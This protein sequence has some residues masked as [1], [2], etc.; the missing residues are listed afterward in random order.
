MSPLEVIGIDASPA[1]SGRTAI[2]VRAILDAAG[3]SGGAPTLVRLAEVDTSE[4]VERIAGAAAVVLGSPVYRASMCADLKALLD[5]VPRS[6]DD[7]AGPLA[8]KPVAVLMTGS[9][10]HHFLAISQLRDI[11][12][13]FFGA[14]VV[15]PGLYVS[16]AGFDE[17]G[18]LHSEDHAATQGAALVALARAGEEHPE[19]GAVRPQ[20]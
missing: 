6:T 19:L 12:A 3:R 14:W 7:E 5:A 20:I 13:G 2:A 16:H 9:T 17:N 15:P 4:V 11:L 1:P 8:G 10:E 18:R